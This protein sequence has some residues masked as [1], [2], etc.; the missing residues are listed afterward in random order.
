MSPKKPLLAQGVPLVLLFLFGLS[1]ARD[2]ML[3][4]DRI[5]LLFNLKRHER[6]AH[7]RVG[8]EAETPLGIEAK[9]KG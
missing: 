6:D 3:E 8:L 2:F 5:F 7:A 4:F 9:W 1:S